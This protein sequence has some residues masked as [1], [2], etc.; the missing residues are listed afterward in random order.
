M[1]QLHDGLSKD[2]TVQK[3]LSFFG[4]VK[5]QQP[6]SREPGTQ[7]EDVLPG[8]SNNGDGSSNGNGDGPTASAAA[9]PPRSGVAQLRID[10]EDLPLLGPSQV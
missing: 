4:A 3:V 2:A 10:L 5:Q 9:A 8:S 6:P 7:E 1:P